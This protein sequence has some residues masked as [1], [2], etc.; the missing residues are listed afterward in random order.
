M[1]SAPKF[2]EILQ[3]LARH[4]VDFILVGGMATIL[5]GAPISTFDL[6]I[7][8]AKTAEN[9]Q[10]CFPLS[11]RWKGTGKADRLPSTAAPQGP[12][13]CHFR[14]AGLSRPAP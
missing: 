11:R 3:V 8:V 2:V 1:G 4:E 14:A 6:D 9:M 5:A 10:R 13:H 7:V 12:P